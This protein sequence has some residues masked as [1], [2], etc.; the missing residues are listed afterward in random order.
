MFLS[1]LPHQL[2]GRSILMT[3]PKNN[4]VMEGQFTKILY[5]TEYFTMNEIF[6]QFPIKPFSEHFSR[7]S[8][9]FNIHNLAN[10]E[11]INT[12][13]AVERTILDFYL[14]N[15]QP[16]SKKRI[17]FKLAEQLMSGNMNLYSR[18]DIALTDPF[19]ISPKTENSEKWHLRGYLI[20]P[21]YAIKISGV[22]ETNSEIGITFK[23]VEYN[24]SYNHAERQILENGSI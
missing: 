6:V 14:E 23:L 21:K 10:V 18:H 20:Q 17:T 1:I 5:S 8:L 19:D 4:N 11:C 9:S 15:F 22:W 24:Y 16:S 2:T 7:A 13:I 3:E 12:F